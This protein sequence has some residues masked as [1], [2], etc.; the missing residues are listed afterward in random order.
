LVPQSVSNLKRPGVEYRSFKEVSPHIEIGLAWRRDND[1]PV[2]TAFINL[3][4]KTHG[5]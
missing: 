3:M 2:L 4:R 5:C 1:S